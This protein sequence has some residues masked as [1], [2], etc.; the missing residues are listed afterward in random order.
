MGNE[1]AEQALQQLQGTVKGGFSAVLGVVD[2][3]DPIG[4]CKGKGKAVKKRATAAMASGGSVS[5]ASRAGANQ[6]VDEKQALSLKRRE[7]M[8]NSKTLNKVRDTLKKDLI[9]LMFY[10]T[11]T[12]LAYPDLAITKRLARASVKTVLNITEAASREYFSSRVLLPVRKVDGE[13]QHYGV[14]SKLRLV[15]PYLMGPLKRHVL[16]V[17]LGKLKLTKESIND[18]LAK[19]WKDGNTYTTWEQGTRAMGA[20]M[21]SLYGR[22]GNKAMTVPPSGVGSV[23]HRKGTTG[24]YALVSVCVRS[25]LDEVDMVAAGGSAAMTDKSLNRTRLIEELQLVSAFWPQ[26]SDQVHKDVRLLDCSES[27]RANVTE[28]VD[29]D[30]YGVETDGDDFSADDND[31]DDFGTC[32]SDNEEGH[33]SGGWVYAMTSV[34]LLVNLLSVLLSGVGRG[35]SADVVPSCGRGLVR[36]GVACHDSPCLIS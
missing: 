2:S 8:Q 26:Q 33:H 22:A 36:S 14:W 17:H 7:A 32:S 5:G 19:L 20:A 18:E 4:Q 15:L 6:V 3:V 25:Y 29:D 35:L 24:T 30:S 16:P 11:S 10:S 12:S 34:A 1:R 13:P 28:H 9:K 23:A 31:P 27:I 21:S